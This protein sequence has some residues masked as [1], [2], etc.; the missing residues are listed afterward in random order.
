MVNKLFARTLA[1][2]SPQHCILCDQHCPGPL[3]LCA[4]C[5]AE[6]PY[7]QAPLCQHCAL[8]LA[9]EGELSCARCLKKLPS[10][11]T[12]V[13]GWR[14]QH[15]IDELITG[16]K[17]QTKLSHG[18]VL[19]QLLGARIR[20]LYGHSP[21]PGLLI[22]T[23]LHWRRWWQ[24]GYN[25]SELLAQQLSKQLNI[26]IHR[27]LR[28]QLHTPK[29]QGLNAAQRQRNLKH[30]FK[31]NKQQTLLGQCVAVV[32]DV[33]TTTATAE[34]MSRCLLAAGAAEVHIWCLARTP[35]DL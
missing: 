14:Y 34:A 25:Q 19:G 16:F 17:Y 1:F 24:R 20:Q 35:I 33:V 30:A 2:I 23:P 4:P 13:A 18:R 11:S 12:L 10:F 8:P 22:P 6:L 3:D 9:N 32:D 21:Q 15:P 29:Q 27:G 28:R 7:L 5:Q 31:V 26:P